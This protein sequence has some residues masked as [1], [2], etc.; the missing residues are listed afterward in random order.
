MG[1]LTDV[2]IR[3]WI[4]AGEAIAK[5]DGDGL[6]FTLSAKG[7]AAWVLRYRVPSAKSQKE[8]TLGRY[9][10]ISLGK[11]RELATEARAKIQQGADV[12]REKQATKRESASAWTV[13]QLADDYMQKSEAHLAQG[14]IDQ[15][16][17]QLRAHVFPI[18]G[19]LAA[20]DVTPADIVTIT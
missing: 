19:S 15:R 12:A 14:T 7:T 4:K 5:A 13:R 1:Q 16:R 17:Q 18:I 3:N 6:T 2:Q 8:M 20:K 10:D 9:P 11:A